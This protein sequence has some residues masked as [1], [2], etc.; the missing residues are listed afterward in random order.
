M[1]TGT[2]LPGDT[3][4]GTWTLTCNRPDVSPGAEPQY[5]T[6]ADC[7]PIVAE[8]GRAGVGSGAPLTRPSTTGGNVDPSPVA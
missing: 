2:L 1:V 5:S 8:Q 7:P 6:V 3:D 4:C